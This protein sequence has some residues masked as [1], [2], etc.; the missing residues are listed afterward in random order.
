VYP[1]GPE[2]IIKHFTRSVSVG[3]AAGFVLPSL[4]SSGLN[5]TFNFYSHKSTKHLLSISSNVINNNERGIDKNY[6]L[7][8]TVSNSGEKSF[9]NEK[10]TVTF[11]GAKRKISETVK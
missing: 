7:K 5:I 9:A 1:A 3:C 6:D 11:A 10:S 8:V 4:I 2:P